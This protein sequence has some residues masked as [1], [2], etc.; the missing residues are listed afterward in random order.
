M[1]VITKTANH[2]KPPKIILNQ[3]KLSETTQEPPKTT[4]NNKTPHPPHPP[5][6]HQILACFFA[7][8]FEHNF[9]IRKVELGKNDKNLATIMNDKVK[10]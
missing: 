7:V 6:S 3:Q 4:C 9:T 2:L 10:L 1:G 5:T 8:D